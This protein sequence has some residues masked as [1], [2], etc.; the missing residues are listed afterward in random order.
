MQVLRCRRCSPNV[1][2][3]RV[4]QRKR[5]LRHYSGVND[6]KRGKPSQDGEAT[7]CKLSGVELVVTTGDIFAIFS[8]YVTLQAGGNADGWP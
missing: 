5:G 8:R 6:T 2:L 4:G 1:P 7:A 3:K